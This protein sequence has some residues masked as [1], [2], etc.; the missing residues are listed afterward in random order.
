MVHSLDGDV[1]GHARLDD[2]GGAP[3]GSGSMGSRL[4]L[5]VITGLIMYR[6]GAVVVIGRAC[7]QRPGH[8]ACMVTAGVTVGGTTM[9]IGINGWLGYRKT[10]RRCIEV[11]ELE[12]E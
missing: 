1:A 3:W 10:S 6:G 7:L 4:V 11:C 9:R 8:M 12:W 5:A 2:S